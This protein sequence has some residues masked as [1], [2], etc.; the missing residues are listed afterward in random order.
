MNNE[1]MAYKL[2]G[3]KCFIISE[4]NLKL[5]MKG[6]S[7]ADYFQFYDDN[8]DRLGHLEVDEDALDTTTDLPVDD[9]GAESEDE[10]YE[11]EEGYEDGFIF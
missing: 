10:Y 9:E 2:E 4:D 8:F 1:E 6:F 3:L 11:D 7:F 5:L